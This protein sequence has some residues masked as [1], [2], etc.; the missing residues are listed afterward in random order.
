M[1]RQY[2]VTGEGVRG[3]AAAGRQACSIKA[4]QGPRDHSASTLSATID[5]G[6]ASHVRIHFPHVATTGKCSAEGNYS[7][8]FCFQTLIEGTVNVK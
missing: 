5:H 4:N 8:C 1:N 6:L 2:N 7:D 3:G